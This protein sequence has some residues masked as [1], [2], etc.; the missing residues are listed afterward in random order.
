[1]RSILE[2]RRSSSRTYHSNGFAL[3]FRVYHID[4]DG[5][6]RPRLSCTQDRWTNGSSSRSPTNQRG[7]DEFN[8]PNFL[9]RANGQR[10]GHPL[11]ARS[12][13]KPQGAHRRSHTWVYSS[14]TSRRCL[15][16]SGCQRPSRPAQSRF[17]GVLVKPL[18][19]RGH[20]LQ[21]HSRGLGFL[22]QCDGV[23]AYML[24][25]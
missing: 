14:S 1:M 4:T 18:D 5:T 22:I 8:T 7:N 11:N 13:R 12:R 25:S 9:F 10:A 3:T 20:A 24:S 19:R 23:H 2:G 21:T 15:L 16:V 6:Q 17:V